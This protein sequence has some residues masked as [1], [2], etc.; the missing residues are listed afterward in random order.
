DFWDA[1][2]GLDREALIHDTL[3][4]LVEQGRPVSLGEL[5]SLLP[6]AHDLETFALWLAMAR[7]AGIEV[8]TEERQLVELVDEDE[9]RW[10]F[11]LPYVGLDHEALKDIDWEL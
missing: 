4:V 8:L 6:P 3:A 2:D 9:Q 10:R 5:A 7:E 1:F 11:N